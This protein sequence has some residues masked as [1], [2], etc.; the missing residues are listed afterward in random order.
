[1]DH[2]KAASFVERQWDD[3]IVPEL[4]EYIKIPNKSPHFDPKW[5]EHGY[6]ED[7]VTLIE[8]WCRAQP[9]K[10]LHVEVVRLNGRTPLIYMEV[11]GEGDD[12][13]LLYGHLDKQPEM[14]GC[15]TTW[16]HSLT[17]SATPT[18]SCVWIPGAATTNSC[19]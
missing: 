6:M 13:I 2:R 14:S 4:V 10:D 5:S 11:P 9:I 12:T 1:M 3:S 17:G 15:L 7:A 8:K 16:T 18:S 19:G